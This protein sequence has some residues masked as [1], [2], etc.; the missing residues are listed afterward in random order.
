MEI[1]KNNIGIRKNWNKFTFKKLGTIFCLFLFGVVTFI[2]GNLTQINAATS[3][4]VL[5]I[6]K[7]GTGSNSASVAATNIL[8]N[9][10][11]NYSGVLPVAKGGT[12]ATS[13]SAARDNL[14][15]LKSYKYNDYSN[16]ND[17]TVFKVT[18]G[19]YNDERGFQTIEVTGLNSVIDNLIQKKFIITIKTKGTPVITAYQ[20]TGSCSSTEVVGFYT[21]SDNY[22]NVYMVAYSWTSSVSIEWKDYSGSAPSFTPSKIKLSNKP[23]SAT[24][25][26]TKCATYN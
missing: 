21:T 6:A 12:A 14:G 18:E 24:D 23:S 26:K 15:M 22:F 25:F 2:S 5:P 19:Y 3:S 7:G 1:K 8:G 16:W 10:Y 9:N 11:A 4:T 13:A 20:L 17:H